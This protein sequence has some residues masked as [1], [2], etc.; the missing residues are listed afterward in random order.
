M[1]PEAQK[2]LKD[3][4]VRSVQ[5]IGEEIVVTHPDVKKVLGLLTE[6]GAD[7]NKLF[8][9]TDS[10]IEEVIRGLYKKPADVKEIRTS[11]SGDGAALVSM[12]IESGSETFY[13][14]MALYPNKDSYLVLSDD[15]KNTV[16]TISVK[17]GK[18]EIREA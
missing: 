8:T 6:I 13:L 5:P 9:S 12:K 18:I 17:K 4:K 14:S 10:Q 2:T 7:F 16:E 3:L 1:A 11:S 15:K